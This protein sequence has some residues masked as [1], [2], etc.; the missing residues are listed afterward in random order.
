MGDR[1]TVLRPGGIA[2]AGRTPSRPQLAPSSTPTRSGSDIRLEHTGKAPA[3]AKP[4]VDPG[5]KAPPAPPKNAMVPKDASIGG[6]AAESKLARASS[7]QTDPPQEVSRGVVEN[8]RD[9]AR[10]VDSRRKGSGSN[11]NYTTDHEAHELAWKRL[12]GRGDSPP[13]FHLPSLSRSI[14]LEG[15]TMKAS[16]RG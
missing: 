9:R 2:P 5:A 4:P 7:R 14:A 15:L 13:A 11:V 16:C 1:I 10:T 6:A 8:I 3:P 12:G